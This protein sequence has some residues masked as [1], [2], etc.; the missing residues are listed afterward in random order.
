MKKRRGPVQLPII[1]V[2][3]F[4]LTGSE[5]PTI[6]LGAVSHNRKKHLFS[7]TDTDARNDD[8][9]TEI[10]WLR[11]SNRKPKPKLVDYSRQRTRKKNIHSEKSTPPQETKM[12]KRKSRKTGHFKQKMETKQDVVAQPNRTRQPRRTAARKANY[13]DLSNS[14]SESGNE[15][16]ISLPAAT[17]N[18]AKLNQGH[19]KMIS[20]RNVNKSCN[21]SLKNSKKIAT[22]E[23][24]CDII[25]RHRSFHDNKWESSWR[26]QL[27]PTS[28]EKVRCSSNSPEVDFAK[29]HS[30]VLS[31][32]S[33]SLHSLTPENKYP[34][35]SAGITVTSLCNLNAGSKKA[36]YS[37]S[38]EASNKKLNEDDMYSPLLSP[39][40]L[41]ALSP[42]KMN[43]LVLNGNGDEDL[44]LDMAKDSDGDN[45]ADISTDKQ[46]SPTVAN[47]VK[48]DIMEKKTPSLSSSPVS[49]KRKSLAAA[50]L[51][52]IHTSGP[53]ERNS[54]ALLKHTY[55]S[56][57][58]SDYEELVEDE[59]EAEEEEKGGLEKGL[60]QQPRKLFKGDSDIVS[61]TTGNEFT[62]MEI[63]AWET[64]SESIDTVY[65]KF[66]TELTRKFQNRYKKVDY[67]TQ[68][69]LKSVQQHLASVN[70]KVHEYTI[71]Q[72]DNFQKRII[73]ELDSFEKDMQSVKN[74]EKELANFWKKQSQDLTAYHQAEKNRIWHLKSSF[75]TSIYNTDDCNETIF[76]S[77][78]HRMKKDMKNVQEKLLKEM[79]E[80]ELFR[81][82]KG[83]HMLFVSETTKF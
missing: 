74:M 31:S 69:S 45:F 77:Q 49:S 20:L 68:H 64:R 73:E 78:A 82:R 58:H 55:V 43:R 22:K 67:F 56:D 37:W 23:P 21:N 39:V 47:P 48:K 35:K 27:S 79:Q 75:E 33:P 70:S 54:S 9:K 72:L 60:K 57:I 2:Y 4:K 41:P 12:E 29:E 81:V 76:N 80:E 63:D 51:S 6:K 14:E 59:E 30:S 46:L 66:S 53:S 7:D 83:L 52:N 26:S 32:P 10:S 13:K 34:V 65:E 62:I 11:E 36:Q 3:N 18:S 17:K 8:S 16:D 38:A 19:E 1:D 24:K 40:T 15:S 71:K 61:T 5:D 50:A 25:S 28:I 42:L 44:D